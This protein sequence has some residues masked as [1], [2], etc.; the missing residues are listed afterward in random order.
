MQLPHRVHQRWWWVGL[1]TSSKHRQIVLR[2]P[3]ML[4]MNGL[5]LYSLCNVRKNVNKYRLPSPQGIGNNVDDELM[6]ISHIPSYKTA[7][8]WPIGKVCP[9][10]SP[11]NPSK[12]ASQTHKYCSP[13][14]DISIDIRGGGQMTLLGCFR[15]SNY[16]AVFRV[17]E[18]LI[19]CFTKL[20]MIPNNLANPS[21][22]NTDPVLHSPVRAFI[23]LERTFIEWKL[24]VEHPTSWN[25][26]FRFCCQQTSDNIHWTSANEFPKN[27]RRACCVWIRNHNLN[28]GRITLNLTLIINVGISATDSRCLLC[29]V[30]CSRYYDVFWCLWCNVVGPHISSRARSRT[31]STRT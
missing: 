2:T 23:I 31:F 22:W 8:L 12:I 3:C 14:E 28:L 7:E 6:T 24:S 17:N 4:Q 27:A 15:W 9:I 29:A 5:R 18:I 13:L 30:W 1:W 10:I 26:T 19:L 20:D 16:L 11:K 25:K 21:S